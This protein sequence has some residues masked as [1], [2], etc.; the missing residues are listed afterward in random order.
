VKFWLGLAIGAAVGGAGMYLAMAR[1][2]SRGAAPPAAIA[3]P[4]DAGVGDGKRPIKR[5]RGGGRVAAARDA[6]APDDS[7][8]LSAA[9]RRLEWRGDEVAL[10]PQTIDMAAG[11]DARPL[12]PSEIQAAI[13]RNGQP[14]IDCIV[15]A[16][17]GAPLSGAVTL[18]LLVDGN[19]RVVRSRV[20]AA[21][22]LFG[23]GLLACAK[24]AAQGFGFPATGAHTVV[25][26]PF[27]LN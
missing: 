20:Q 9:D 12:A 7:I 3:A 21:S 10:P 17:G 16:I 26:A 11:D 22:Y 5:R 25:T 18:Q 14:M 24:R 2:W 15:G 19:G 8:V 1:P 4:I 23:H 27:E 13:D 6:V